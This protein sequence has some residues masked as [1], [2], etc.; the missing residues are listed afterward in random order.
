MMICPFCA[1]ESIYYSKKNNCY[2]CEDCDKRFDNPS[3]ESGM[4]V[5]IS[6]GHDDNQRLVSMIKEYLSD[7]GFVVWIDSSNI[8]KGHDWRERITDG[9]AACN[10]VVA[11]LS[12]HSVRDPGVCLDELRIALRLKHS[13]KASTIVHYGGKTIARLFCDG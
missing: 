11:F 13:R 3:T 1:S 9:L 7:K 8:K 10:G 4:R 2:L 12:K 5:F 6:Y